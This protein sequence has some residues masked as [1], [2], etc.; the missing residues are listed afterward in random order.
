[1]PLT[2]FCWDM[3]ARISNSVRSCARTDEDKVLPLCDARLLRAPC[4]KLLA[5]FL[6]GTVDGP[7]LPLPTRRSN[8]PRTQDIAR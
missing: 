2:L 6:R 4:T 1:M 3:R 5:L 8:V 7:T